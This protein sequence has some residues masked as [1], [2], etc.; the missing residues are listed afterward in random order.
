[1]QT[2]SDQIRCDLVTT[3]ESLKRF[4]RG[5]DKKLNTKFEL[6]TLDGELS[7]IDIGGQDWQ[8]HYPETK[9]HFTWK[10]VAPT[11]DMVYKMQRKAF[12]EAFNSL[13]KISSLDIDFEFNNTKIT[14][15]T[16]AFLRDLAVFDNKPSV[17]AHAYLFSPNSNKNG[18]VEFNDS[19]ESRYYFTPLGWPVEA[20][21]VDNVH[22]TPGQKDSAGKLIMRATQPSVEIGMHEIYHSFGFRHDTIHPESLMQP[23]VK[24]GYVGDKINSK[25]FIWP[26]VDVQ[27]F[28]GSYGIGD[29]SQEDLTRWDNYRITPTIYKSYKI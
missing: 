15:L 11:E 27:R 12:Q 4:K 22:F 13:Q 1:M 26:D 6:R 28:Q 18:I 20:Y 16:I 24:Q 10:F 29:I 23:Y 21:L 19:P 25:A 9:K 2:N 14:D 17:L 8:Y 3:P 7:N 5:L